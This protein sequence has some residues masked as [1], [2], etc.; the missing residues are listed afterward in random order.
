MRCVQHHRTPRYRKQTE[1]WKLLLSACHR[2]FGGPTPNLV[3]ALSPKL[4]VPLIQRGDTAPLAL[5]ALSE[6]LCRL[7]RRNRACWDA[8]RSLRLSRRLPLVNEVEPV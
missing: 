5:V 1:G 8:V 7:A 6:T 4:R 3:L 2:V